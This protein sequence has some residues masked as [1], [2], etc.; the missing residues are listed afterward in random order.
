M[1]FLLT[2]V[3]LSE[4]ADRTVLTIMLQLYEDVLQLLI[5]HQDGIMNLLGMLLFVSIQFI[6][7]FRCWLQC[8]WTFQ[9]T[10]KDSGMLNIYSFL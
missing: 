9:S 1:V 2:Q 10:W 4:M 5:S 7:K 8:H 3:V 6:C